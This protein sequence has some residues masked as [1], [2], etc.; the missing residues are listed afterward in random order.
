MMSNSKERGT[1][2]TV[3]ER[4]VSGFIQNRPCNGETHLIIDAKAAPLENVL[5]DMNNSGID[6]PVVFRFFRKNDCPIEKT[7]QPNTDI[8][9][10]IP[11]RIKSVT[12][13]C[14]IGADS[15]NCSAGVFLT[16]TQCVCCH[17]DE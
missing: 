13:T 7:V 5:A 3:L 17:D 11:G 1:G 9:F 8:T 15:S 16:F 12:V 14:A 4:F 10:F 6:C 2:C